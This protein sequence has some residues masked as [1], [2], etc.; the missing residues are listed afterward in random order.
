MKFETEHLLVV[1]SK[2]EECNRLY[3]IAS[4]W[5]DKILIEGSGVEVGYFEDC[6]TNGDLPPIE[7][8]TKERYSFKSIILKESQTIIGYFDFYRGYPSSEYVWIS[9]FVIDSE[10]RKL[11]Y[12]QEVMDLF[13]TYCKNNGFSKIGIGV[14]LNNWRALRFW[15]KTGFNK[16]IGVNCEGDYT[17]NKFATIKLE[18]NLNI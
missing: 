12:S 11:G 13:K 8:A 14:Y 17:E 10:F 16:V 2:L 1:D 15:T 6:I 3:Q 4:S 9:I 18:L 5:T 7:G